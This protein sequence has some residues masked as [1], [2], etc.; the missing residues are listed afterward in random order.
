MD[1]LLHTTTDRVS[2]WTRSNVG[3]AVPG[4]PTPLGWTIWARGRYPLI[5][6]RFPLAFARLPGEIR[7]AKAA[8]ERW[9]R[10][11]I[12]RIP[13]LGLAETLPAFQTAAGG[14]VCDP[15]ELAAR[16]GGTP[17][18][19]VVTALWRAS[20]ARLDVAAI[21]RDLG[22]HTF[23]RSRTT[24]RSRGCVLPQRRGTT[25]GE[26]VPRASAG[27]G[28]RRPGTDP[29]FAGVE[30]GEILVAPTT[31]PS[32][33][34]IMFLS[35]GLVVDIGG[36]LSHAAIAAREL[37]IPCVVNTGDGSRVI[38]DGDMLRVDGTA[39]T[40]EIIAPATPQHVT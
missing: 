31:D 19:A 35:A 24:R 28:T 34:S 22:Y 4:V 29:T 12:D 33:A 38:Q 18:S 17:E 13:T 27:A 1:D 10:A 23:R 40:V 21:Q 3:E 20:R 11:E 7:A 5:A 8:T 6:V 9:W 15:A 39:G 37:G 25:G 30:P 14:G 32:W 16:L 2:W 36:A 26:A